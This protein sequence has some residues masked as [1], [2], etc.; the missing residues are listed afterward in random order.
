[1]IFSIEVNAAIMAEYTREGMCSIGAAHG[2]SRGRA[3]GIS[4]LGIVCT[5]LSRRCFVSSHCDF[6]ANAGRRFSSIVLGV[7]EFISG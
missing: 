4:L 3:C 5:V 7:I 2:S 6:K 1:M